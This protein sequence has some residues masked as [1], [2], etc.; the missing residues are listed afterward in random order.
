MVE[1]AIRLNEG[2]LVCGQM[3]ELQR[4]VVQIFTI[5]SSLIV[6]SKNILSL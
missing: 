1:L 5:V 4:P 3:N 6:C 2:I